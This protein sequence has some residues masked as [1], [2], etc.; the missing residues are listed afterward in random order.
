MS[1]TV[2][3]M[4]VFDKLDKDDNDYINNVI[5]KRPKNGIKGR[6]K[7]KVKMKNTIIIMIGV[8]ILFGFLYKYV[9]LI[10][11]K[12]YLINDNEM[13][14][15]EIQKKNMDI[16][17]LNEQVKQYSKENQ[18]LE[19]KTQTLKEEAEKEK[20][21][22]ISIQDDISTTDRKINKLKEEIDEL[23]KKSEEFKIEIDSKKKI[24]NA[25]Q[26]MTHEDAVPYMEYVKKIK[27][28]RQSLMQKILGSLILPF[29][30]SY[31]L[32]EIV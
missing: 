23:Q 21:Q 13:L 19:I 11:E 5:K 6:K 18:D 20:N 27:R 3:E 30:E 1:N 4:R 25:L 8:G 16:N 14:S 7:D 28:L 32:Q 29:M 2:N 31:R 26:L 17:Q 9:S 15:V 24:I 22:V 10:L 12:R